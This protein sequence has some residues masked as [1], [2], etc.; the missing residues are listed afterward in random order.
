MNIN[1]ASQISVLVSTNHIFIL[2]LIFFNILCLRVT[3]RDSKDH[4][5]PL[6]NDALSEVLLLR[7]SRFV[8]SVDLDSLHQLLNRSLFHISRVN[9]KRV[10]CLKYLLNYFYV[11]ECAV[12]QLVNPTC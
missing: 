7:Q 9:M 12:G 4:A 3:C 5:T 2:K 6:I 10:N 1:L 8:F 11:W